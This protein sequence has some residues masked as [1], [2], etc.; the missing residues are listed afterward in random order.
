M[1]HRTG[2]LLAGL[3]LTSSLLVRVAEGRCALPEGYDPS[4]RPGAPEVAT[5][6]VIGVFVVDVDRVDDMEQ[7]FRVDILVTAN[8]TDERL[9]GL[10][11]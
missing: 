9:L 4:R 7:S 3:W 2:W 8:W 11:A 1:A 6:V 5:P 10:P